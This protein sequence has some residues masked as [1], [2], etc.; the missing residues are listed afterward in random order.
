MVWMVYGK[1]LQKAER[2]TIISDIESFPKKGK[3]LL[4]LNGKC[5]KMVSKVNGIVIKESDMGESG[6]RIV[7]LTKEHGKMLLSVR[8]AKNTKKGMQAASQLFSCCEF[9][10]FEGRGFYSVT[11]ADVI[12]SFYDIRSDFER[13]SYGAYIL[14][15]TERASFEELQ[16]NMAF[17]LLLRTLFVLSSGKRK[18]RLVAAIYVLRLLKEY[19][20][21][22]DCS[23][24]SDCGNELQEAYYSLSADDIFCKDCREADCGKLGGGALKALIHVTE[25]PVNT[26]FAFDVSDSVLEELWEFSSVYRMEYLGDNYKTLNYINNIKF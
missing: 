19:G 23:R 26:L 2:Y 12:E 20:F 13:L 17:D 24:C 11:Q 25:S 9:T 14:E 22:G 21:V 7:V 6:K 18:P 16:N 8:G 3:H 5:E 1:R 4:I 15:I 10:V